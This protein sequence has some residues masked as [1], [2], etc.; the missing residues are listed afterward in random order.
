[1]V[2]AT[3]AIQ[4]ARSSWRVLV[5]DDSAVVRQ[6]ISRM[7]KADFDVIVANDGEAGWEE[8]TKDR[9]VA[10]L[11]TDIEMPRL[12]GYAFICRVRASDEARIRDL[13]IIVIT[14]ADDDETRTRAYACG[15]T[16][17]ITK[18]LDLVQLQA[19]IQAYMR[20][21]QPLAEGSDDLDSVSGLPGRRA[22]RSRAAELWSS[23]NRRPLAFLM[24]ALDRVRALYR[25]HGDERVDEFVRHATAVIRATMPAGSYVARLGGAEFGVVAGPVPA[26]EALA[27]GQRLVAAL[28]AQPAGDVT[29]TASVGVAVSDD[30]TTDWEALLTMAGD[31]LKRAVA[32]GGN[33]ATASALSDTISSAEELVLDAVALPVEVESE[34]LDDGPE[35]VAEALP[36]AE[37]YGVPAVSSRRSL[38]SLDRALWLLADG[39]ADTVERYLDQLVADMIPLLEFLEARR[40]LGL[41][42]TID[43]LR[44]S[45]PASRHDS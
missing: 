1:M 28:A 18:P 35:L 7:L 2:A 20:F 37:V 27:A 16:D 45:V 38:I 17:F 42:T 41:R 39:H 14:G 26:A 9:E 19:C 15:A 5:V 43:S 8:L 3:R 4:A 21:E 34:G 11:I 24:I 33:R 44:Q 36:G 25:E 22:L 23:R 29:L 40:R 12:D 13:P 31:R 32:S 10:V 30:T 6:A